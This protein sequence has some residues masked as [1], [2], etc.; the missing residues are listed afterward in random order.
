MSRKIVMQV[1]APAVL[2]GLVTVGICLASLWSIHRLQANLNSILAGNVTSLEA[3]A[4]LEVKLRQLRFHTFL[5]V[6]DPTAAR[7]RQISEAE[8]GFEAALAVAKQSSRPEDTALV[9][10]IEDGFRRYRADRPT[11]ADLSRRGW[12]RDEYLAWADA[13]PV[14]PLLDACQELMR[15]NREAMEATAR[16]SE[17]VSNRTETAMSG[18]AILGPIGGLVAGYG[19]ARGLSR[20]IAQLRVR[21]EDVRAELDQEVAS[22]RVERGGL[23]GLDA[24]LAAVTARVR[25]VV[26]QAQRRE[27]EALRAEQLAA[28]GQLAAGVAHEV[29]NPLVAIKLLIESALAGGELTADDLRVIH[30][31]VGRL[32]RAAQGLLDFARPAPPRREAADLRSV[33]GSAVDLVR[34][35]AGLQN[36]RLEVEVPPKPVVA[37]VDVAQVQGALVNLLLNA[38]DAM[39]SGG[40]VVIDVGR[41]DGAVR[42]TVRDT[43]PGIRAEVLPRLFEPFASTRDTGTGLGLHVSRRVVRDHG[44]DIHGANDPAG[45]AVFTI[46]LPG[47]GHAEAPR[48]R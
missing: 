12:T 28:V 1:T 43:G 15:R 42:L 45:G 21:V 9:A 4:E 22:V 38:L 26:E 33:V 10:Q 35:R 14:Q 47:D 6:M 2:I 8:Q 23:G 36:V 30:G 19:I 18:L 11:S 17:R 37:A 41:A 29:R 24:E 39:P 13:H 3:A 16:E 48:D 20:S 5:Y 25:E 34:G 46:T 32:E 31:E 40:R 27:R 44:G 7:E